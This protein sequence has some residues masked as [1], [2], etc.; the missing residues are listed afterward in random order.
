MSRVIAQNPDQM[1]VGSG[2]VE[3]ASYNTDNFVDLGLADNIVI[4]YTRETAATIDS[5]GHN[6]AVSIVD[7]TGEIS[8]DLFERFL[9]NLSVLDAGSSEVVASF[10]AN[11]RRVGDGQKVGRIAVRITQLSRVTNA[12]TW[13]FPYCRKSD[14]ETLELR[15]RT[16]PDPY[17]RTPITIVV[18]RDESEPS[19]A[20][21]FS[22]LVQFLPV[23]NN[24][25]ATTFIFQQQL[26][27][28]DVTTTAIEQIIN[29]GTA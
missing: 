4:R 12:R 6:A 27:G 10:G 11:E 24:G 1:I 26:N 22:E 3:I 21:L 5:D 19:A 29:G 14:E 25:S 8:F 15:N 9:P 20:K 13:F 17:G 28:G 2:R 7:E 16:S 18:N 23:Y